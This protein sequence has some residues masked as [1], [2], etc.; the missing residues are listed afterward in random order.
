MGYLN[1]NG[2]KYQ[3]NS[4]LLSTWMCCAIAV[5]FLQLRWG[6]HLCLDPYPY[7]SIFWIEWMY[8]YCMY[9][10]KTIMGASVYVNAP[11]PLQVV[12]ASHCF[13]I[14]WNFAGKLRVKRTK[15]E[16]LALFFNKKQHKQHP[17]NS[18]TTP[19]VLTVQKFNSSLDSKATC[20]GRNRCWL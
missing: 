12:I 8:T 9:L 1:V 17:G 10:I 2:C 5:A 11:F 13:L 15:C 18:S 16:I 7:M 20:G 19:S 6:H 3:N 4:V 14:N